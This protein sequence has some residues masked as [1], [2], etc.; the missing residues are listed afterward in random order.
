MTRKEF[1]RW[2]AYSSGRV[3]IGFCDFVGGIVPLGLLYAFGRFFGW[4]GYAFAVKHRRIAIESLTMAFGKTKTPQEIRRICRE[5][6]N[7]MACLAVEFFMFMKHPERIKKFVDIEGIDNLKKALAEG[8]GVVAIS[9]HFG[10]FPLLLSRL[11][12]EECK[13]NA[14]MRHMRDQKLD[15]LFED[16]RR[17][18]RVGSIYT[19]PRQTCVSQSLKVLRDNE[20]L[21]VQLDQNFGT[22]GVFVDFF[23]VKAATA[24]GPIVFS[25]RTGAP[26]VPMFIYRLGGPRHRI[27]IEPPIHVDESGT[28]SER[29]LHAVERLT[30]LIEKYIRQHPHEWGW[31]HKRWKAR[32]KEEKQGAM[33]AAAGDV[34]IDIA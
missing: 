21:F 10:S 30:A 28:K 33:A 19:Q 27:V 12:Q 1:C 29:L 26:I 3:V 6:F 7:S 9:A 24:T 16:K 8:K 25:M 18:M 20:V 32:P 2:M 31:I 22:G 11:A 17:L 4:A 13:V 14:V 34:D 15:E 23:G 5:C